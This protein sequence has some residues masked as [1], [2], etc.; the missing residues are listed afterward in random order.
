MK[1]MLSSKLWKKHLFTEITLVGFFVALEFQCTSSC[2][3]T[4]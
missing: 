1:A 3:N 2:K 4:K